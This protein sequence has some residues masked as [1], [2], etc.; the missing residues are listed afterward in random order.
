LS[1]AIFLSPHQRI[2]RV[3]SWQ[4]SQYH[5]PLTNDTLTLE[6][7]ALGRELSHSLGGVANSESVVYDALGRVTELTNPLG[8][9]D[10]AYVNQTARLASMSYPNGTSTSYDYWGATGSSVLDGNKKLRPGRAASGRVPNL[11]KKSYLLTCLTAGNLTA[12][13]STKLI[14]SRRSSEMF[15]VAA[16]LGT[17]IRRLV[18]A[19]WLGRQIYGV[20]KLHTCSGVSDSVGWKAG[21]VA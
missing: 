21:L 7:D 1:D 12:Q 4:V 13:E 8:H 18:F 20:N 11:E 14:V 5:G 3:G 10:L 9:F 6:Y 17:L 19:R 15:S 16:F 2:D